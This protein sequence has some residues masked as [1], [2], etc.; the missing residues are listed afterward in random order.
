ML[1]KVVRGDGPGYCPAIQLFLGGV[2]VPAR[3]RHLATSNGFLDRN[4]C[5]RASHGDA[6]FQ[7]VTERDMTGQA[8]VAA[9]KCA[10]QLSRDSSYLSFFRPRIVPRH[11]RLHRATA[12]LRT[13]ARSGTAN[14]ERGA[15]PMRMLC[16]CACVL[17]RGGR[18]RGT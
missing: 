7:L 6:K 11:A 12:L 16:S 14:D 9:N 5:G 1:E 4:F 8:E 13:A 2:C 10:T 3:R 17:V 15:L 18:V